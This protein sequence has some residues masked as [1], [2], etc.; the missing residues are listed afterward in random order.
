MAFEVRKM[1]KVALLH[2][3]VGP[4]SMSYRAVAGGAQAVGRTAGEA[5]DALA[6]QLP[7]EEA[8]TF[9]IV[10]AM[11]PDRFFGAARRERLREL[12]VRKGEA[13]SAGATLT[14]QERAELTQLIDAEVRAATERADALLREVSP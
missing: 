3:S 7:R 10:R 5:L 4:D 8:E 1:T 6:S 13:A 14:D 12:M 11:G 2:E 9:V